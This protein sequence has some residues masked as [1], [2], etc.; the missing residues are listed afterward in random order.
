M[1][2]DLPQPE[3]PDQRKDFIL[4][5]I[6]VHVLDCVDIAI[7]DVH[8]SRPDNG[9]GGSVVAHRPIGTIDHLDIR[10]GLG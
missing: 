2:V 6:Q 10:R 7:K 4:A 1:N 3:G 9:R 8:V 5:N